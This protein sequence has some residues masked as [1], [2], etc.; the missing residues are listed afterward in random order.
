[1]TV[2]YVYSFNIHFCMKNINTFKISNFFEQK[3]CGWYIQDRIS[4]SFFFIL[5]VTVIF[6]F[7][8][9]KLQKCVMFIFFNFY[10]L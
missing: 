3:L 2:S 9:F 7:L 1:M 10:W 4:I 5:Y 6:Y 8:N